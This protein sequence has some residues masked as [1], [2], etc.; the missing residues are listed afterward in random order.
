[1][2]K[3]VKL[4]RKGEETPILVEVPWQGGSGPDLIQFEGAFYMTTGCCG[5]QDE[6][7][8]VD[9]FQASRVPSPAE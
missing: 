2:M 7:F 4:F 9:L 6:Y 1:M 8:E 5:E 3:A